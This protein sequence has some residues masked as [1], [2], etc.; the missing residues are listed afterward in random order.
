M[1]PKFIPVY[2]TDAVRRWSRNPSVTLK[3]RRE[4]GVT[5]GFWIISGDTGNLS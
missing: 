1:L 3:A 5:T 4:N 2:D